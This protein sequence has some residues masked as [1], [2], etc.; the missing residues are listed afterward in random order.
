MLFIASE[1]YLYIYYLLDMQLQR[2]QISKALAES[3]FAF[4]NHF[5]AL[6]ANCY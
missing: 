6:F 3:S 1:I 2:Q 4:K 5:L